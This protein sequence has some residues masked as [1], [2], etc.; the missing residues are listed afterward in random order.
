MALDKRGQGPSG[1]AGFRGYGRA[2]HS[3]DAAVPASQAVDRLFARLSRNA[4]LPP[5]CLIV[6]GNGALAAGVKTYIMP[7]RAS[8]SIGGPAG[9]G[10]VPGAAFARP[11]AAS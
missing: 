2:R 3:A 11:L 7:Q 4:A 5:L 1:A 10:I 8:S 9:P 6:G